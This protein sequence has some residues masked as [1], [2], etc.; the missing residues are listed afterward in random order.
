MWDFPVILSEGGPKMKRKR[1][2]EEQIITILK[3]HEAGARV[4]DLTREHG[5]G[6][7]T[8]YR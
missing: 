8:T 5:V 4:S 1:F 7:N 3:A 2:T 6:E